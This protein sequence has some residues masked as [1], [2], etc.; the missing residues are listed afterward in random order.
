[1]DGVLIHGDTL[2]S[3]EMR[4]ELPLSFGAP[5]LCLEADGRRAVVTNALEVDR[6]AKAAPDVE[7]L[8]M[9]A[10]GMDELIAEGRSRPEIEREVCVRAVAKL[11]IRSAIVPP[12]FPVALADRLRAEG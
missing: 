3:P 10:L 12:E 1:M 5:F 11:G 8:L 2:R 9:N 6:I 7:R 4:H